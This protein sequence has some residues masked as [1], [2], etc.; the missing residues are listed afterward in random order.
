MNNYN[1][2]SSIYDI[3][4]T[5]THDL[6]FYL[7]KYMGFTGKALELMAGTGR[8]SIPLIKSGI[9]L[10][11]VDLS[12]GLLKELSNKLDK[13]R[14]NSKLY[15][16]D[17]SALK[18]DSIYDLVIIAFNSFSEILDKENQFAIFHSVHNILSP[19][20]QFIL[21]LYNPIYRRKYIDNHLSVIDRFPKDQG[22]LIFS[23]ASKELAD[24][25]I[26]IHQFYEE[27]D[28]TGIFHSKKY[29]NLKFK[30]IDKHEIE[31]IIKT[32]GFSIENIYGN[33]DFSE[34]DEKSSPYMLYVL[35][36]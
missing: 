6:D 25:I 17:I 29:L 13:Y 14:L 24:N 19:K 22:S 7:T 1:E 27:F 28:R 10:D 23:M 34:Y 36:K 15:C 20:G 30:L 12:P 35:N 4:N 11:C 2:V 31:D 32:T 21:T 8:L 33:Y 16:Q 9:Q 5:A 18:L 26:D 3:Y